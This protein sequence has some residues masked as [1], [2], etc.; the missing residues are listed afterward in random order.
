MF[1]DLVNRGL[2]FWLILFPQGDGLIELKLECVL[3]AP[4]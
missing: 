1:K 2:S 4:R 3:T